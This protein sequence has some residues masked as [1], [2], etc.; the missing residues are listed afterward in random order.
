MAIGEPGSE[1]K[2]E[3]VET[4]GFTLSTSQ[5]LPTFTPFW[6]STVRICLWSLRATAE[7]HRWRTGTQVCRKLRAF[8]TNWNIWKAKRRY[9]N[10]KK[11]S[12]VSYGTLHVGTDEEWFGYRQLLKE[13]QLLVAIF[14][15]VLPPSLGTR[16]SLLYIASNLGY[17]VELRFSSLLIFLLSRILLALGVH[18]STSWVSGWKS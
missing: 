15:K 16:F 2:K 6:H 18:K 10:D 12:S 11:R 17:K 13:I 3:P 14:L 9:K 1:I 7:E 8:M 4:R 5:K